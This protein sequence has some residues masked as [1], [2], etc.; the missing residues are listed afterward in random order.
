MFISVLPLAPAHPMRLSKALL[1]FLLVL[2]SCH[3]HTQAPL[4]LGGEI[5]PSNVGQLH[6]VSLLSWIL[7]PWILTV[8]GGSRM[9]SSRCF[10]TFCPAFLV[11]FTQGLVQN[12]QTSRSQGFPG[13]TSGK[14]PACQCR[15]RKKPRF[16][17]WV[18]KIP[19]GGY[20][21]PLQYSCLEDTMDRGAW[22]PQSLGFQRVG[23][24]WSWLVAC[25]RSQSSTLF[26]QR[27]PILLMRFEVWPAWV[28]ISVVI[29]CD[30]G[31]ITYCV[32][33]MG[34]MTSTVDMR[35]KSDKQSWICV[36]NIRDAQ[37]K[38]IA[39]IT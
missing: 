2:L 28:Q 6:L 38:R 20:G 34:I 13:G 29:Q 18:E 22:G 8:F 11:A 24:D 31:Q 35:I 15:R 19:G 36:W 27:K 16:D 7:V 26:S 12:V 37:E 4:S 9:L 17:P 39:T 21:N 23:R 33:K 10:V 32:R 14:E 1:S 30:I 25:S 3:P 5:Q